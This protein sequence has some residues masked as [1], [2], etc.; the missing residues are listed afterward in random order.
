MHNSILVSAA[1]ISALAI[2]NAGPLESAQTYVEIFKQIGLP[3]LMVIVIYRLGTGFLD[4]L[5][6]TMAEQHAQFA[7]LTESLGLR[8]EENT[9]MLALVEKALDRR[10]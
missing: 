10:D 7:T 6:K 1:G 2:F 5:S 8:L 4:N 9:A 3:G